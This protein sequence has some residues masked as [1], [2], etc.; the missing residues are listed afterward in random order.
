MRAD[1]DDALERHRHPGAHEHVAA[2]VELVDGVEVLEEQRVRRDDG[3]EGSVDDGRNRRRRC[4]KQRCVA[5]TPPHEQE[6][7]SG[8]NDRN[9][10]LGLRQEHEAGGNAGCDEPS[11]LF[12]LQEAGQ[13][14]QEAEQTE[15]AERRC[16]RVRED[17]A[18]V[19]RDERDGEGD[20][21]CE[22]GA[23]RAH[24]G[25][26]ERIGGEH[27]RGGNHEPDE[28]RRAEPAAGQRP[29]CR[30]ARA[31]AGRRSR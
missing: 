27:D 25:A 10:G 22:E 13:P 4:G 14:E 9:G 8:C 11:L 15:R 6:E 28:D 23:E 29:E 31:R 2:R 17:V 26:R 21:G 12:R 24:E 20:R 7:H 19:V 5:R 30:Q 16:A 18:V 3:E 1:L